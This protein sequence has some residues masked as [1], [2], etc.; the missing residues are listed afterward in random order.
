MKLARFTRDGE[1]HLGRVE[2]DEIVDLTEAGFGTSMRAYLDRAGN[3]FADAREASGSC[4]RLSDVVLEAPVGDPQKLLALGM[5]YQ[6]H[7]DNVKREVPPPATQT[8]F[9]KQ[10]SCI[11]GPS[12]GIEMPKV[13]DVLDFEGELAVIIGKR[14]RHVPREDALSVIAGYAVGNDVSVRDWQKRSP[15]FTLGKS[16]DTHGPFGPWI[17]TADEVADPQDLSIRT[18][19]NDEL[20]QDGNTGMM[21]HKLVDQISYISQVFTLMPGD[22]LFTGTPGGVGMESGNFLKVGDVIRI[23]IDGLGEIQNTVIPEP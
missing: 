19:V 18:W 11:N 3:D 15:T 1:T 17:T 16:F 12:Q 2:G 14:C 9:N 10:V 6:D 7:I 21:I 23:A 22:V 4:Y 8:W 20:R 5:N 13:S